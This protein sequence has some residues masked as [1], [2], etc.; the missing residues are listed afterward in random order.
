MTAFEPTCIASSEKM[1]QI[2]WIAA[3]RR[4]TLNTQSSVVRG[5]INIERNYGSFLEHHYPQRMWRAK[6]LPART[7]GKPW[8]QWCQKWY[9]NVS[10]DRW[11]SWK[12]PAVHE[13]IMK[14]GSVKGWLDGE[15]GMGFKGKSGTTCIS[16][17]P[18]IGTRKLGFPLV[19]K[20]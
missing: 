19:K 8:S 4:T 13:V 10:G 5:G 7:S 20:N 3:R 9:N 11:L 14:D 1:I 16:A 15:V 6:W 18:N 2:F 17:S 12:L